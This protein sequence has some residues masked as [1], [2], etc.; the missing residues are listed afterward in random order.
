[1]P[2]KEKIGMPPVSRKFGSICVKHPDLLGERYVANGTCVACNREKTKRV[3]QAKKAAIGTR[4][5][6]TICA[7]HPSLEGQRLS[8]NGTCVHCHRNRSSARQKK[9]GYPV[10]RRQAEKLK[11]LIFQSYGRECS[12]C[13]VADPDVLTI[14]HINQQ[15]AKHKQPDGQRYSGLRLYRW[16]VNNKF[17]SGYRV[18]CLNCNIKAYKECRGL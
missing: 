11:N 13:G 15:G 3:N 18:L 6:G 2:G 1:M 5:T 10:Q 17:P 4:Y 12:R 9:N 14:D 8:S 16:L 7:K